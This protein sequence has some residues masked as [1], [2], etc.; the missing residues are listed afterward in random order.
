MT[1]TNSSS[2]STP[3]LG[4]ST[5]FGATSLR[6][7]A[8]ARYRPLSRLGRGGMAEVFLAAWEVAPNVHRP[9]VIKRLHAHLSDDPNAARMFVDEARLACRLDHPNIV[10]SFEAGVID[11]TCCIVMEY[12]EGAPLHRLLRRANE[13]GKLPIEFALAIGMSM[14][15]ALE[16]AHEV[17]DYSGA[18][19][20][21]VHRDISPHNV[22]VT[23][24]GLVKVLD[25]G[26][27]KAASHENH[28]ATGL[29][30]G[31]IGYIAPEQ[32]VAGEV[33]QRADL[34]AAGIVLWEALTG[35]RLF[36]G[37]NDIATLNLT[38]V[39]AIP[40][41]SELRPEVPDE[42]DA[43]VLRAL[44]RNPE[45]RYPTA[46]SMYIALAA[47]VE[48]HQLRAEPTRLAALVS[49]LFAD[50]LF[51]Q[52]RL[53][54]TSLREIEG[55]PPSSSYRQ[56][57]STSAIVLP[58][59]GSE[60]ASDVS[61]VVAELRGKQRR[62]LRIGAVAVAAALFAGAL[63]GRA[64]HRFD[65]S[66]AAA[67]PVPSATP[68]R[69]AA[70]EPAPVP[71]PNAAPAPTQEPE[72]EGVHASPPAVVNTLATPRATRSRR[73]RESDAAGSTQIDAGAR[74]SAGFGLVTLDSVP[75]SVVSIDGK[76]HGQTPLV[77]VRL[78]AGVHHVMMQNAELGL[79]TSYSVTVVAGQTLSRR[80]GLE[81]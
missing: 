37:P 63:I 18:P 5:G 54:S 74:E 71:P 7:G 41:P 27:A 39:G 62:V 9:V 26:I 79:Q 49:E 75:W 28:T 73:A 58:A 29:V 42:L 36:K 34:F 21:I 67:T 19:L 22:F 77:N 13:N 55:V 38:L 31:K 52:R 17:R 35:A 10:R 47:L 53:V 69:A 6:L 57:S 48:K 66:S 80:I 60:A 65:A 40:R 46:R 51:E 25:F 70:S 72:P 16:Y 14:L 33:D 4:T 12:L 56:P 15:E 3:A 24:D 23:S 20:S 43:I 64:G 76:P 44:E 32:A 45:R 11:G 30:K 2:L 59:E 8:L 1:M 81:R 61:E 68:I 50:E 78:P